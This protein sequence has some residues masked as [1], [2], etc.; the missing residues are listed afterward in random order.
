MNE[1]MVPLS[2]RFYTRWEYE[3]MEAQ[4]RCH[5]NNTNVLEKDNFEGGGI[6]D[7][8]VLSHIHLI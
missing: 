6:A 1:A 2:R 4:D 8:D 7:K 3:R 5:V